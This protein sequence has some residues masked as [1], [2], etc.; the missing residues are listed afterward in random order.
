MSK[1]DKWFY[2]HLLKYKFS[3]K[4]MSKYDKSLYQVLPSS[5]GKNILLTKDGN[6]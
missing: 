4:K 3:K 5:I 6:V 2:Q 1:H